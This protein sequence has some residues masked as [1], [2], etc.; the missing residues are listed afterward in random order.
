MHRHLIASGLLLL[1]ACSSIGVGRISK[2]D[3][4]ATATRSILNSD[5]VSEVTRNILRR[6]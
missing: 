2:D 4:Y 6:R 3:W 1:A 5:D